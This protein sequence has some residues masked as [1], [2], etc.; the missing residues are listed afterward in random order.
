MKTKLNLLAIAVAISL[1]ACGGGGGGSAVPPTTTTP[2]AGVTPPN[3]Q[4][5]VP[6]PTYTVGSMELESY[7]EF[8]GFR[9]M[10]GVG[11]IA[12]SAPLDT[13]TK[14]HAFYVG[15]NQIMT[16]YEE[17]LKTGFTGVSPADRM[18]FAQ[19][20]G[21]PSVEVIGAERG[22]L[23]VR[24]LMN[25]VY[26]RD[27]ILNQAATDIGMSYNSLWAPILVMDFG[28]KG[29]GQHNGS[30]Y[31]AT[32]PVN[33]QTDLPLAMVS[34]SPNPFAD[35]ALTYPD[36]AAKTS[37]P[38]SVYSEEH[39]TLI[40]NTFTVTENG[41]TTPLDMRLITHQNDINNLVPNYAVHIVGKAPFK[42]NTKYNVSFNGNVNGVSLT[43]IWSFTTGS[44]IFYGGGANQ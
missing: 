13:S 40:V 21:T 23:A 30:D 2:P 37:S 17:A 29:A 28:Q 36:F 9:R 8:S 7:V 3:L 34:E 6:A 18:S 22:K 33:N 24:G 25:S 42:A 16:H 11:P 5:N 10:M 26:H 1:T 43:K 44:D 27:G 41:Q 35:V 32:Y 15:T 14:N 20:S 31:T 4:V 19:Y 39:T 12:Q 38:V